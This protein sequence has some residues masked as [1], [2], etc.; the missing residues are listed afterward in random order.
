MIALDASV[1]PPGLSSRAACSIPILTL[2]IGRYSPMCP[3]DAT[4]ACPAGIERLSSTASAIETASSYPLFPVM[5]FA[6]PL[7]TAIAR[8]RRLA[9]RSP[10][11]TTGAAFR[12]LLVKTPAATAGTLE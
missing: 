1:L 4:S 12:E 3:V 6:L 5:E 11:T 2:S 10:D 8:T 9:T 7:F